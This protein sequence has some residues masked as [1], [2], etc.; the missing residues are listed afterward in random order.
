MSPEND[1]ALPPVVAPSKP[2]NGLDI[3]TR[4]IFWV[5]LIGLVG[6]GAFFGYTVYE[7]NR[8]QML[9]DPARRAVENLKLEVRKKPNDAYTRVRLAEAMGQAG[10]LDDAVVQLKAALGIDQKY[11]GAYE[12]LALIAAKKKDY[13]SAEAYLLKVLDLTSQGD[14]AQYQSVNDRREMAYYYLG[15]MALAQ[16]HYDDAAAYLKQALLIRRD[17]SDT[18]VRLADAYLGMGD[19]DQAL[20]QLTIAIAYDPNFPEARFEI[21]KLVLLQGN[22]VAAAENFRKSL[23]AQP[24]DNPAQQALE[25]MGP[26]EKWLESARDATQ[27]K[28]YAAALESARI[29][30]AID[31]SSLTAQRVKAQ[32]AEAKGDKKLAVSTYQEI[33]RLSPSDRDVAAALKR[34]GVKTQGAAQ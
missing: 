30:V 7:T 31:P 32:A 18:Y 14:A 25:A 5:L 28:D 2:T 4:V 8:Q 11:V 23:N 21:G 9:S 24:K 34:L 26:I 29:A 12:D 3:A 22:K 27:K 6:L 19:N 1:S 20:K 15:E 16:K 17:A 13:K 33:L 10:M